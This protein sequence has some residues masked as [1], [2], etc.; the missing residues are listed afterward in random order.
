M[1][2]STRVLVALAVSSAWVPLADALTVGEVLDLVSEVPVS[3]VYFK[4]FDGAA[5]VIDQ[6]VTVSNSTQATEF[7]LTED[8]PTPFR[9]QFL[10]SWVTG[11]KDFTLPKFEVAVGEGPWVER[12]PRVTGLHYEVIITQ[13]DLFQASELGIRVSESAVPW[14]LPALQEGTRVYGLGSADSMILNRAE[15]LWWRVTENRPGQVHDTTTVH[16]V[17]EFWLPAMPGN[18]SG[19]RDFVTYHNGTQFTEEWTWVNETTTWSN[20]TWIEANSTWHETVETLTVSSPREPGLLHVDFAPAAGRPNYGSELRFNK[21]WL[22]TQ[23][24]IVDPIVTWT[25]EGTKPWKRLNVS[26]NGTY[27]SVTPTNYSVIGVSDSS[28][29]ETTAWIRTSPTGTEYTYGMST[30]RVQGSAA[31][32]NTA[33]FLPHSAF[34][35]PVYVIPVSEAVTAISSV[36]VA[37]QSVAASVGSLG[38]VSSGNYYFDDANNRV[39]V[40]GPSVSASSYRELKYGVTSGNGNYWGYLGF[41]HQNFPAAG[42]A[43]EKVCVKSASTSHEGNQVSNTMR[44]ALSSSMADVTPIVTTDIT[45]SSSYHWWGASGDAQYA[46]SG[47]LNWRVRSDKYF[48]YN[49]ENWPGVGTPFAKINAMGLNGDGCSGLDGNQ[50]N[51]ICRVWDVSTCSHGSG[52]NYPSC[53]DNQ[54]QNAQ[55]TPQYWIPTRYVGTPTGPQWGNTGGSGGAMKTVTVE[56]LY[57]AEFEMTVPNRVE[58][59]DNIVVQGLARDVNGDPVTGFEGRMEVVYPDGTSLPCVEGFCPGSGPSHNMV[60][61]NFLGIMSTSY[62]PPGSYYVK[63]TFS[64]G[65]TTY[66]R[67]WPITIGS[68]ASGVADSYADGVIEYR[69]YDANSG[70]GLGDSDFYAVYVSPDASIGEEDRVSGGRTGVTTGTTVY[71]AVKDYFGHTVFPVTGKYVCNGGGGTSCPFSTYSSG[72]YAELDVTKTRT[73]FDIGITLHQVKVKNTQS[74]PSYVTLTANSKNFRTWVLPQEVVELRVPPD[75]YAV[76]VEQYDANNPGTPVDYAWNYTGSAGPY[77]MPDAP[78][79]QP[80]NPQNC[81]DSSTATYCS[82]LNGVYGHL[83]LRRVAVI[84]SMKL[85]WCGSGPTVFNVYVKKDLD[86]DEWTKVYEYANTAQGINDFTFNPVSARY[87]RIAGGGSRVICDVSVGYSQSASLVVDSDQFVWI[88]GHD[89]YSI[90][91]EIN[92]VGTQIYNQQVNVGVNINNQDSTIQQQTLDIQAIFNNQGTWIGNQI[93]GIHQAVNNTYS[94]I[95]TQTNYLSQSINT[96]AT[97]LG[98]QTNYLSQAINATATQIGSQTNYLSQAINVTAA[99][100]SS[101]TNYLSLAVNNTKSLV[102]SQTNYLGLAVNNT[103]AQIGGQTNYLSL[104]LNNTRAFVGS[105]TNYLGL[106]LNNT[107]AHIESQTNAIGFWVNNTNSTIHTQVNGV[108]QAVDNANATIHAQLTFVSQEIDNTNASLRDQF[109]FQNQNITNEFADIRVQANGVFAQVVNTETNISQQLTTVSALV[110]TTNSTVGDQFNVVRGQILNQNLNLSNQFNLLQQ[111]LS[112]VNSSISSQLNL[113]EQGVTNTLADIENQANI[114]YASLTNTEVNLSTQLNFVNASIQNQNATI[115]AQINLVSAQLANTET[116]LSNQVNLV[117]VLVNNTNASIETQAN[118]LTSEIR[119]TN[120]SLQDQV[121]VLRA[122][123]VNTETN[124]TTQ[125]NNLWFTVNNS[126]SNLSSQINVAQVAV[127]NGNTNITTQL[128]LLQ[129]SV[130]NSESNITNQTNLLAVRISTTESNLTQQVTGVNVTVATT[131]ASIGSQVNA[132]SQQIANSNLSIVDQLN[133]VKSLISTTNSTIVTQVS[134]LNASLTVVQSNINTSFAVLQSNLSFTENRIINNITDMNATVVARLVGLLDDLH[135]RGSDAFNQTAMVLSNITTSNE[136]IFQQTIQILDQVSTRSDELFNASLT[137]IDRV[138]IIGNSTVADYVVAILEN[139]TAQSQDLLEGFQGLR[140]SVEA[141]FTTVA[142]RLVNS[143]ESMLVALEAVRDALNSNTTREISELL[144]QIVENTTRSGFLVVPDFVYNDTLAPISVVYAA[145][146]YSVEG[147]ILVSWAA[148]DSQNTVSSVDVYM[149]RPHTD[150]GLLVQDGE[151]YGSVLVPSAEDGGVYEFKSIATD[152]VGNSEPDPTQ[153]GINYVVFTY[154]APQG[155]TPPVSQPGEGWDVIKEVARK[156]LLVPGP[157]GLGVMVVFA[158]A[159]RL[160]QMAEATRKGGHTHKKAGFVRNLGAN[161]GWRESGVMNKPMLFAATIM[162][163]LGSVAWPFAAADPNAYVEHAPIACVDGELVTTYENQSYDPS[164]VTGSG[165]E[166]DPYVID[167]FKVNLSNYGYYT[168]AIVLDNCSHVRVQNFQTYGY[169]SDPTCRSDEHGT[170]PTWAELSNHGISVVNSTDVVVDNSVIKYGRYS[171]ILVDEGSSVHVQRTDVKTN[172][173]AGVMAE[174]GSFVNVSDSYVAW[175]GHIERPRAEV[176]FA[177]GEASQNV[178]GIHIRN[179]S[180][181]EVFNSSL[182]NNNFQV[183][184]DKR[185]DPATDVT[186][187]LVEIADSWSNGILVVT[188]NSG[189]AAL[190]CVNTRVVWWN[191]FDHAGPEERGNALRFTVPE[192]VEVEDVARETLYEGSSDYTKDDLAV[193]AR[194]NYWAN[195]FGPGGLDVRGPVDWQ[196]WLPAPPPAAAVAGAA[197]SAGVYHTAVTPVTMAEG[198]IRDIERLLP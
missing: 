22:A 81:L 33:T 171:G 30:S 102:G 80:T 103:Y 151:R 14:S 154:L 42:V 129:Q 189:G 74:D 195:P 132:L 108:L 25:H 13:E 40:G 99:Q 69:F 54:W 89:L 184:V 165:T 19:M 160:I 168:A 62:I 44:I 169:I 120:S 122:G 43:I 193:N 163:V 76:S 8:D 182:S 125:L 97:Q 58:S 26:D 79:G 61:G 194:L 56:G 141:N 149:R 187:N 71:V 70:N 135:Q 60:D 73:T 45:L 10:K 72:N 6:V 126:E 28:N 175:N 179:G 34:G 53:N 78:N 94:Q 143:S 190:P 104:A 136:T 113:F 110:N 118:L 167:G 181:V 90:V 93:V 134:G 82:V 139:S 142:D 96:T 91:F 192:G 155:F 27:W 111:N 32:T 88:R 127:V 144:R 77:W 115:G 47:L 65:S 41:Q 9:A 116:N 147:S 85:D 177:D 95:G 114:L 157:S 31:E 123:I 121:N 57:G 66:T 75:T 55:T 3:V 46:C 24:G 98:A 185:L 36:Q 21:S 83:D 128:N 146:S 191:W 112:V 138:G 23:Y 5:R 11:V 64:I 67:A 4:N 37:G 20:I 86:H 92:N 48:V 197:R 196:F 49:V 198:L 7:Q 186:V 133:L 131:N 183:F 15:P 1:S 140:D 2:W 162:L 87:L 172:I 100:I 106:A 188:D 150:W 180:V 170:P 176:R 145:A 84:S 153:P 119:N 68:G 158:A 18:G 17:E 178:G 35:A 137:I 52:T 124:V 105:Q 50:G 12:L 59:G 109:N 39:Y 101:Q 130:D 159:A 166:S 161:S 174:R 16:V 107:N 164:G 152:T 156:P 51:S 117:G 63:F 29:G 173:G 148:T 38:S